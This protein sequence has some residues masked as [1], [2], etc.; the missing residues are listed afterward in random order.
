MVDLIIDISRLLDRCM[1][2]RLPTG[3]DRVSMEYVRHYRDRARALVR[4]GHR[5]LV[6]GQADSLQ[7][8]DGLLACGDSF[9]RLARACVARNYVFNWTHRVGPGIL[10]N[11][12][13]SGLEQPGY[14]R[15]IRSRGLRA[16]FFLHDLIPIAYP[17]YC[18]P[19][20]TVRHQRRLET[21]LGNGSGLVINSQ[22]TL[23]TLEAHAERLGLPIPAHVVAPLASGPLPQ[24]DPRPPLDVPYFVMVGTI[25]PRKNHL[26]MLGV[27]RDLVRRMGDAVP[28][29]VIIGQVGWECEAVLDLLE[30]CDEIRPHVLHLES[31]SDDKLV[32]WLRHAR[33]LLFPSFAEGYGLPLVEALSLGLPAIVS[34]IP[35]FR[36][37]A[38]GVPEY[39]SPIDGLGWR[40]T[41]VAYSDGE[42]ARRARQI[43][44]LRDFVAPNWQRH[45]ALADALVERITTGSESLP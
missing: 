27:W 8:F 13:H 3:V 14:G 7:L 26:L 42:A 35:A 44:R 6:L 9:G 28:R 32:T 15:F 43:A 10:I 40:D 36:E 39:I 29:L 11:T 45:F 18:R 34:D 1:Q 23:R 38:T 16:L 31:C 41:V 17:E 12:G 25:E 5:W 24:P 33:A 37:I 2:G 22:S 30:R 20:E 4:F 19:G 21:M